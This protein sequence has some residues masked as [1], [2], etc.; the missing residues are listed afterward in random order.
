MAL[1]RDRVLEW[2]D[3]HREGA[4]AAVAHFAPDL[5][6]A[7]YARACA[8]VRQWLRRSGQ[9][10]PPTRRRPSTTPRSR[11]VAREVAAAEARVEASPGAPGGAPLARRAPSALVSEPDDADGEG[12]PIVVDYAVADL[13]SAALYREVVARLVGA[14]DYAVAV[15][16]TKA[17]PTIARALLDARAKYDEAVGPGRR[18]VITGDPRDVVEAI[19]ARGDLLAR[20]LERRAAREG[21]AEGPTAPA[22]NEE[23]APGAEEG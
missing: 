8:Q 12:P 4:A 2:C 11:A 3:A 10:P 16:S 9:S 6:G 15:R 5:D 14:L 1:D 7:P 21:G 13:D 17:I 22:D 23:G 18:R 19:Q 20:L